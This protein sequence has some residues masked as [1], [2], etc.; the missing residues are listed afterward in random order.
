[1]LDGNYHPVDSSELAFSQAGAIAFREAVE[2]AGPVYLEPT[3][4]LEVTMPEAYM[5]PVAGDLNARRAEIVGMEHRGQFRKLTAKVP[6]ASMF[7]YSTI[8]RNLTQGRGT[9]TMEPLTYSP[10]PA[11]VASRLA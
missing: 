5:G 8:L 1:M 11:E 6:L 10:V 3:M 4:R 7:G 9:Y 2:Q